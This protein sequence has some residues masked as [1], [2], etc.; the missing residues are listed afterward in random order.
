LPTVFVNDVFKGQTGAAVALWVGEHQAPEVIDLVNSELSGT[1]FSIKAL[2][3]GSR[4]RVQTGGSAYQLDAAGNRSAIAPFATVAAAGQPGPTSPPG[5]PA[6]PSPL[7]P[8]PPT[9]QPPASTTGTTTTLPPTTTTATTLPPA[10]TT[11]PGQPAGQVR[12]TSPAAG[13]TVEGIALVRVE[14]AGTT[15]IRRVELF[16]DGVREQADYRWP[17][18]F[19]WPASALP[20]GSHTLSATLVRSD[21]TTVRSAPVTVRTT[22][23]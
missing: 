17:Y 2:L 10:T 20:A 19:A 1:P 8:S 23:R 3:A 13:S 7:P 18:V 4:I 6:P 14:T 11:P 21:G 22:G 9:T 5:L 16:A 12:I 15:G